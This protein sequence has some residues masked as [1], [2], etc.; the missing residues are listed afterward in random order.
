[1]TS[2]STPQKFL[3]CG[4]L[5]LQYGLQPFLTKRFTPPGV[6]KSSIVIASEMAK[7]VIVA[8]SFAGVSHR[9]MNY[10]LKDW[11]VLDSLIASA[12]PAILYAVQNLLLQHAYTQLD[13]MTFNVINQTKVRWRFPVNELPLSTAW[14]NSLIVWVLDYFCRFLSMDHNG[15]ETVSSSNIFAVHLICCR[16]FLKYIAVSYFPFQ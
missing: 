7:V 5:A 13:S 4:L 16:C 6:A 10:I 12:V 1:M 2:K 14:N 8:S 11:T 3:Y 15:P 9:E